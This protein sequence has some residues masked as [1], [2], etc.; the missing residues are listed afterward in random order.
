MDDGQDIVL[1]VMFTM[2]EIIITLPWRSLY[3]DNYP[4]ST[5]NFGAKIP[6]G[7]TSER[8][9]KDLVNFIRI[10]NLSV[11]GVCSITDSRFAKHDIY[12]ISRKT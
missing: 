10:N 9:W 11:G 3:F 2:K 5:K 8:D 4:K 12:I 7:A 6:R 1:W